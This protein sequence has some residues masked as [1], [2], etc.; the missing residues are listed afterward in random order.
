MKAVTALKKDG[1]LSL[2]SGLLVGALLSGVSSGSFW[3]G[4]A[5]IGTF[6]AALVFGLLRVWR[7]FGNVRALAVVMIVAFFARVILGVFLLIGLQQFGFNN[8]IQDAGYAYSDAAKRDQAAYQM[9]LSG[10]SWL[11]S[12]K[13]S[14]SSDQYGGLLLVS[15]ALYRVFSPDTHRPLLIVL[16]SAFSMTIGLAFLWDG[17]RK[18]WGSRMA[19]ASA[20]VLALYPDGLMLGSSQMREPLLIGL[21]CAAFWFC[22]LWKERRLLAGWV[23]LI[24]VVLACL[25][26]APSGLAMMVVLTG[27]VFLEWAP[28]Q[29]R[30]K[31]RVFGWTG[32]AVFLGLIGLAGWVWLRQTI[33]YESYLTQ[34]S[35]GWIPMLFN[36]IGKIY[37]IPF[38]AFY[39]VSQ[40][41]LP[42]ALVDP[43]LPIWMAIAI[44]RA[45]GWYLILPFLLYGTFALLNSEK[46]NGKAILIW[47]LCAFLIWIVVSSLRGGGDQWDNPRYRTIFLPW[48]AIIIAWVWERLP[49]RKSS[50]FPCWVLV[51]VVFVLFFL[52]WYLYRNYNYGLMIPFFLM[53]KWIAGISAAV[54]LGGFLFDVTRSLLRKKSGLR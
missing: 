42:A 37:Q 25:I 6:S 13:Q 3:A 47:F 23:C 7:F 34:S 16:L 29:P 21:G 39:G 43:S 46:R 31:T 15:A 26:S 30:L 44:F 35:S 40:P 32:F 22:L 2:I 10:T 14:R 4:L 54:F 11:D 27:I 20:W 18:R 49:A 17:V 51:E 53:I 50:Y 8:P 38:M 19:L 28:Q 1:L 5:G 33:Y 36:S 24:L 41:F 52:N 12:L 45:L 48:M 9:A